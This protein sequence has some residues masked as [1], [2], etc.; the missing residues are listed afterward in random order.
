MA[1]A[2]AR[3]EKGWVR[4]VGRLGH[5]DRTG[6][7]RASSSRRVG[8]AVPAV[9]RARWPADV[10]VGGRAGLGPPAVGGDWEERRGTRSGPDDPSRA[11]LRGRNRGRTPLAASAGPTHR[12][13]RHGGPSRDCLAASPGGVTGHVTRHEPPV[14]SN[15]LEV[16]AEILNHRRYTVI[17][18]RYCMTHGDTRTPELDGNELSRFLAAQLNILIQILPL[19]HRSVHVVDVT[20]YSN[21]D[22]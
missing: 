14:F 9:G 18:E 2:T 15:K 17:T 6:P 13:H 10:A 5:A 11:G 20:G 8:R 22:D 3:P 4:F 16:Q 7:G 21:A 12:P 1:G 19:P